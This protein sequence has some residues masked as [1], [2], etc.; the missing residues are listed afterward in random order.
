MIEYMTI[1]KL[2]PKIQQGS[3]AP[4]TIKNLAV[5]LGRSPDGHAIRNPA[6]GW[7]S[8]FGNEIGK[9]DLLRIECAGKPDA[10]TGRGATFNAVEI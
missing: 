5:F 2:A 1:R 7:G 6:P 8:I 4:C 10:G 3:S 9:L